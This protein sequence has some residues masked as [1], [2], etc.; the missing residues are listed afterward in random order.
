LLVAWK[1]ERHSADESFQ[2][3]T[4]RHSEEQLAAR[5]GCAMVAA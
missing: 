3:F 4:A 2:A 5:C 1:R